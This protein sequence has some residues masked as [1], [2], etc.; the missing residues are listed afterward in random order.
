[1]VAFQYV[2]LYNGIASSNSTLSIFSDS[3]LTEQV[4]L[5]RIT[6]IKEI[7]IGKEVD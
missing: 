3:T 2:M 6:M 5:H 1:M 4:I 7:I